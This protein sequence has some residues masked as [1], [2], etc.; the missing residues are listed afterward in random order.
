MTCVYCWYDFGQ[1]VFLG[2]NFGQI[3]TFIFLYHTSKK[4]N[5][6]DRIVRLSIMSVKP[7]IV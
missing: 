1:L 7:Y 3:S 2:L 5:Y 4:R 6:N